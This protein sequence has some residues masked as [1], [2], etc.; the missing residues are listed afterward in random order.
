MIMALSIALRTLPFSIHTI[1]HV[2]TCANRMH[3]SHLTRMRNGKSYFVF[4]VP[5]KQQEKKSNGW[6]CAE[7][8]FRN[9]PQRG[10]SLK[11]KSDKPK[12][13][14]KRA[15]VFMR[16]HRRPDSNEILPRFQNN[17]S[18]FHWQRH[19]RLSCRCLLYFLLTQDS[20]ECCRRQSANEISSFAHSRNREKRCTAPNKIAKRFPNNEHYYQYVCIEHVPFVYSATVKMKW[21]RFRAIVWLFHSVHLRNNTESIIPWNCFREETPSHTHRLHVRIWGCESYLW[22]LTLLLARS[23]FLIV[24]NCLLHSANYRL[25]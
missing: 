7:T 13:K 14:W 2:C 23:I 8:I 16:L 20:S 18:N 21:N 10:N 9:A 17:L 22:T 6:K 1:A 3:K 24:Q 11:I 25:G 5:S 19:T 4:A 15:L 12:T